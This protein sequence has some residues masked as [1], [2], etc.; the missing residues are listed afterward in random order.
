MVELYLI[1]EVCYS[2]ELMSFG[3]VSLIIGLETKGLGFKMHGVFV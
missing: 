3:T 1:S 2:E